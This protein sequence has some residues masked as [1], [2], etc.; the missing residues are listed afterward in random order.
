MQRALQGES[1]VVRGEDHRG[2][3]VI[4]AYQPLPRMAGAG[5]LRADVA[6]FR[7]LASSKAEG[8]GLGLRTSLSIVEAHSGRMWVETNEWG[9][10]TF[11]FT[12]PF[13]RSEADE[14]REGGEAE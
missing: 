13:A 12:L 3:E 10:A 14:S 9:G 1:G 2:R 11:R 6:A 8:L 4:A 5:M 7:A